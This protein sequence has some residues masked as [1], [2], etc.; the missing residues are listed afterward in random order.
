MTARATKYFIV[1]RN[2][3]GGTESSSPS[4]SS[5]KSNY[6]P[7]PK[8]EGPPRLCSTQGTYEKDS[9]ARIAVQKLLNKDHLLKTKRGNFEMVTSSAWGTILVPV[10]D[11]D[12]MDITTQDVEKT[13]LIENFPKIPAPLWARWTSLCFY[14]CFGDA[15]EEEKT[16]AATK[17]SKSEAKSE[18]T[19]VVAPASNSMPVSNTVSDLAGFEA[20]RFTKLNGQFYKHGYINKNWQFIET[21]TPEQLASPSVDIK[22][23]YHGWGGEDDYVGY[24]SQNP[25][26]EVSCV[27]LRKVDDLTKWRILI[28]RQNVTK[29]SVNANFDKLRD[30]E[31][32]EEITQFPPLG[33][34][35]AG[36]S[37]SHNTMQAYFSST[38]DGSELGVPGL[39]IVVGN[40]MKYDTS[41]KVKASLVLRHNRRILD[42]NDV[43]DV[44]PDAAVFHRDVLAMINKDSAPISN[45]PAA[46][47]TTASPAT[48]SVSPKSPPINADVGGSEEP[49]AL[50]KIIDSFS[51]PDPKESDVE[52]E[53]NAQLKKWAEGGGN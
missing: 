40:L 37:H 14:F 20:I 2:G 46:S 51:K 41:Y 43:V 19:V 45:T 16:L 34:A 15:K 26:L 36:S 38:D 53:M 33:W 13:N 52:T 3:G 42:I 47:T 9:G 44:T 6:T 11:P 49:T 17:D 50:D 18:T 12:A 4:S 23:S 39:H 24:G 32:G 28:P 7:A 31:T 25:E 1:R 8:Y 30:I 21:L 10:E 35:H 29:G 48:P 22:A 27:L 5:T